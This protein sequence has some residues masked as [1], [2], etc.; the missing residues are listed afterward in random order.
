MPTIELKRI[1]KLYQSL[2]R[3]R[4]TI[5]RARGCPRPAARLVCIDGQRFKSACIPCLKRWCHRHGYQFNHRVN[6]LTPQP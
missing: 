2:Y 6:Q 3:P 4:C 1:G 5:H